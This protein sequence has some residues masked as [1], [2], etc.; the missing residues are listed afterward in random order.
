MNKCVILV[1]VMLLNCLVDAVA[2]ENK[3]L[4]EADKR[5]ES[6]NFIDANK[7]YLEV[8]KSGFKSKELFQ[9]LGNT[10]YFNADYPAASKWYTELFNFSKEA[11]IPFS[12]YL[13]FSQTLKS[14][15]ETD[16][17]KAMYDTYVSLS[18]VL[19]ETLGKADDYL[20]IIRKDKDLY[21]L[22]P[23][24]V[25]SAGIDFGGAYSERT[26]YFA[27][28]GPP[29]SKSRFKNAWDNLPFLDLYESKLTESGR[30]SSPELLKGDVNTEHLNECCAA[31]TK[32]GKTIYFTRNN[33]SRRRR[34]KDEAVK[35][36]IYR[37]QLKDGKWTHVEDLSINSDEYSTAHPALNHL[38]DKLYF[39]SDMAGSYGETDLYVV[40]IYED[41]TLGQPVN[42]G[43][44]INTKGRESFPF[45]TETDELYF[46]SDGHFGLG[47]YD[48]FYIKLDG[49]QPVSNLVNVGEPINSN[50]DDIAF[51]KY[52]NEL[53]VSSNREGGIGYDDVYWFK[54]MEP[55][56]Y[57]NVK[58]EGT[59]LEKGT[60]LP[61]ADAEVSFF[62]ED[63]QVVYQVYTN[64]EGYYKVL[65]D[66]LNKYIV[67]VKKEHYDG[68]DK[69]VSN[70]SAV[71]PYDFE[72]SRS[73]LTISNADTSSTT[74][75]YQDISKLLNIKI[76]YDT[77]SSEIRSDALI[78]LEKLLTVMRLYPKVK[79][80]VISHT[81]S[82]G[83]DAYNLWLSE[84]RADKI[85]N[86]LVKQGIAM[87]RLSAKG[88]GET[89]LVNRC[90]NGVPC[91]EEEHQANRRTDFIISLLGG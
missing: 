88:L 78:E 40:D 39:S 30:F 42:L 51:N 70:L 85:V 45:L 71:K 76:Y 3:L 55:I 9:R 14:I 37:A 64:N 52:G 77:N 2:Q 87:A 25:N 22:K 72:L 67:K 44:K 35:L 29:N 54:T 50:L 63:N 59:L 27:S 83:D 58:I 21:E 36:N 53:Y 61:I 23:I 41:G 91:T 74:S 33:D 8:A 1:F 17:A 28:T 65:V 43:S 73:G 89:Q 10:Y 6:M 18:G 49:L 75:Y 13:R 66:P 31:F 12:Y 15:G 79:V 84:R 57:I 32:D 7:I 81:D 48:V 69:F 11:D 60:G 5:Y 24:T 56:D 82:V 90:V 68:D 38:E 80:A 62:D 16:Q 34:Q 26:L 46:S 86:Y 19:N 47:G 4:K 20:K